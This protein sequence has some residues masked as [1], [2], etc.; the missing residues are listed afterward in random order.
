MSDLTLKVKFHEKMI[1]IMWSEN[2]PKPRSL[3]HLLHLKVIFSLVRKATSFVLLVIWSEI[4]KGGEIWLLV[5][6]HNK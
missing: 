3:G 4:V 2:L 1:V 5:H 6:V